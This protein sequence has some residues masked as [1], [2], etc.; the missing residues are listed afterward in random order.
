MI[1]LRGDNEFYP[2]DTSLQ[3]NPASFGEYNLN[4][5]PGV[6]GNNM[7]DLD[8]HADHGNIVRKSNPDGLAN[9][10]TD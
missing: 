8:K 1:A 10:K 7:G 5:Y 6:G 2:H 3:L 4:F 9:A